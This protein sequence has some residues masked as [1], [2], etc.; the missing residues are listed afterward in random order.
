MQGPQG[1]MLDQHRLHLNHGPIDLIVQAW[2]LDWQRALKQAEMRFLTVLDE[3]VSEIQL[4]R[5]PLEKVHPTGK[6]ARQMAAA[7]APFDQF[8]TPMAAVA[9]AV[10]DEVC[11][12]MC[13]GLELERAYV[14][15]GGDISVF[16]DL[17]Q[18]F[19]AEIPALGRVTLTADNPS[20]GLATSGWQGRS[21]SLGIADAVTVLACNAAKADVAATL[22]ANAVNLPGHPA[23]S[24]QQAD[25]LQP[26]SDLGA[27]LVTIG[28]G[29]LSE[30]ET[31]EAL[32]AGL[33]LAD[34]MQTS[35]LIEAAALFLNGQHRFSGGFPALTQTD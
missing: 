18:E 3:L 16:L 29:A 33:R 4:L 23:I 5:M 26:D 8:V 22:I 34:E 1:R 24:R 32:G 10:A 14:N 27:R 25:E 13:A 2:G 31:A 7:V 12:A 15:N 9:G 19:V 30:A 28:V 11:N 21:H 20:R 17:G 6:I 35:G